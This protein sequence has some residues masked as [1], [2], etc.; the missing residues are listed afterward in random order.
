MANMSYCRFENTYGDL[1]D[2]VVALDDVQYGEEISRREWNYAKMM[3]EWCEK[4]IENIDE[5]DESNIN[6]ED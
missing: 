2:C 1:A 4:F 5:L 6:F 3:R